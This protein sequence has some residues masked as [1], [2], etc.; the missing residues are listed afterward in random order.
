[1]FIVRN[2]WII[3]SLFIVI[4][5]ALLIWFMR[6][7][8]QITVI[9][10]E[11]KLVAQVYTA[12]GRVQG[13]QSSQLS[14]ESPGLLAELLVESGVKV[15]KGQLLARALPNIMNSR[16]SQAA[17]GAQAAYNQRDEIAKEIAR[18]PLS[19]QQIS[20]ET[21][22]TI[23]N[24]RGRLQLAE[25]RLQ[26]LLQGGSG[27]AKE[28]ADIALRK[29]MLQLTL[30]REQHKRAKQLAAEDAAATA[31]VQTAAAR[32]R[33]A[34]AKLQSARELQIAAKREAQRAADLFE[35]GAIARGQWETAQT[36]LA[37]AENALNAGKAQLEQANIALQRQ[38]EL[39]RVTRNAEAED[40]ALRLEIAEREY[41]AALSRQN[42]VNQSARSEVI[43]QQQ[44][45]VAAAREVLLAATNSGNARQAY[46][47]AEPLAQRLARAEAQIREAN[48]ALAVAGAQLASLQ[49]RAPYDGYVL[50][51]TSR[52]G[53]IIG[54]NQPVITIS[55][56]E[57]A[58]V[59]VDVDE[60]EYLQIHVGQQAIIITDADP[61]REI[62]GRVIDVGVLADAQSGVV[63]VKVQISNPPRWL[64]SGL[65]ADVTFVIEEAKKQLVLPATALLRDDEQTRVYLMRD[66]LV[67]KRQVRAGN[68]SSAGVVIL[69]GITENDLVVLNAGKVVP[70]KVGRAVLR[71]GKAAK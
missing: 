65:T 13:V 22:L 38:E 43:V 14:I 59:L 57:S 71:K 1:M 37:N 10:P 2:R 58:Q 39:L 66:G 26:E 60:R 30:A 19:Q 61:E 16:V 12:S 33:E 5:F 35:R 31:E 51:V 40:S 3:I 32:V 69:A 23:A 25:A 70:G 9:H 44:A 6:R 27:A 41:D 53:S 8:P 18:E 21:A 52:P 47:Q 24:A 64:R 50:E 36:V 11:S 55:Q 62:A 68:S 28:Q 49:I 46:Q 42:E 56:M 4:F 15:H 54:P 67:S 45:E 48:A 29:A 34:E 63:P 7:P 20:A 17:A